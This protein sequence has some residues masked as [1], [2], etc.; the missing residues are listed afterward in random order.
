LRKAKLHFVP[1]QFE[2]QAWQHRAGRAH[3]TAGA[4][5]RHC[6]YHQLNADTRRTVLAG[7]TEGRPTVSPDKFGCVSLFSG[8]ATNFTNLHELRHLFVKIRGNSL[9]IP[10]WEQFLPKI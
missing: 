8:P 10:H 3:L 2:N 4:M 5:F 7:E 6:R 1:E 9:P